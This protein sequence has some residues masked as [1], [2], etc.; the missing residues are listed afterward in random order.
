[1]KKKILVTT[2][3]FSLGLTSLGVTT[4]TFAAQNNSTTAQVQEHKT[5][6]FSQVGDTL[7]VESKNN[8]LTK[9]FQW[10]GWNDKTPFNL[11]HTSSATANDIQLDENKNVVIDLSFN[12]GGYIDDYNTYEKPER[13]I[14]IE[15][16][17]GV[18]FAGE[19]LTLPKDRLW[20]DYYRKDNWG[21]AGLSTGYRHSMAVDMQKNSN[22][23]RICLTKDTLNYYYIHAYVK[24]IKLNVDT[25]V[26]K[27]DTLTFKVG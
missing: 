18:T 3:A 27:E 23:G 19:E 17:K 16:P 21:W 9:I 5:G 7:E 22:V 20:I 6:A 24:N 2:A 26:Y 11:T 15:L 13:Y 1:M 10:D 8:G 14:D 12:L 25:N 4:T